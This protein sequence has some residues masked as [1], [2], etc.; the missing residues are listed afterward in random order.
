[1][2]VFKISAR[3]ISTYTALPFAM[4]M[5]CVPCSNTPPV[6]KAS[7]IIEGIKELYRLVPED[8]NY[9]LPMKYLD[10]TAKRI[11]IKETMEAKIQL[12]LEGAFEGR[13]GN[14]SRMVHGEKG[15]GKSSA[16][17]DATVVAS[18]LYPN[19]LPIYIEYQGQ[20]DRQKS[21]LQTPSELICEHLKFRN[22]IKENVALPECL[23]LLYQHN[24]Y[25]I[26]IADELDFLYQSKSNLEIKQRIIHELAALGSSPSG[27]TY[28]I[29]CG[30]SSMMPALI[31]KNLVHESEEIRAEY[32]LVSEV[33]SLN[34]SKYKSFRVSQGII[35]ADFKELARNLSCHL[36]LS[37]D[38]LNLF[39]FLSG[40][41]LRTM[42]EIS[43]AI[44][45]KS[46]HDLVQLTNTFARW[47]NGALRTNKKYGSLIAAISEELVKINRYDLR[48]I[49]LKS[50]PEVASYIRSRN[51]INTL[52]QIPLTQ[53]DCILKRV[54]SRTGSNFDRM[55]VMS[56]VDKG[57]F[58]APPD[59]SNVG[60]K[61]YMQLYNQYFYVT[62]NSP[63][64]WSPRVALRYISPQVSRFLPSVIKSLLFTNLV[65]PE[66]LVEALLSDVAA[67][68]G[69]P[70]DPSRKTHS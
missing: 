3:K 26:I 41:N 18:I 50:P 10:T 53:V 54:N 66:S 36:E 57:W 19:L 6:L 47:E 55:T 58:S 59:L 46:E 56:L 30:S 42:Y 70:K 69:E 4:R 60:P 15:I 25:S 49:G 23:R 32:P 62:Y 68:I 67:A 14:A 43:N 5:T 1:M 48:C 29:V 44:R 9:R 11:L 38:N 33:P 51:W 34:G 20:S 8:P 45:S 63:S 13:A 17:R 39:Y 31:S 61:S 16:F 27:R 35:A 37:E 64:W 28:T 24:L 12:L 7:K 40:S 52:K 2:L 21:S 22:I 65:S